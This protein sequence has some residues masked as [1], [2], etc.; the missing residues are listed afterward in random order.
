MIE[1]GINRLSIGIQSF[2]NNSLKILGRNHNSDIALKAF[3]NARKT[4]F[5]NINIDLI[6]SIKIK[7]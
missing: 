6:Q 7:T 3:Y 4:G 2:D 5:K 1:G